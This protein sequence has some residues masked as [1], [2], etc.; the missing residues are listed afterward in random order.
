MATVM[1]TDVV[2]VGAGL[3]GLI[4]ARDLVRAGMSVTVLEAR[5]RVGGRT[6]STELGGQMIDLGGQWIGDKHHKL[7]ALTTE[8]GIATFP[9]YTKGKKILDRGEKLVTFSGF[10][11]RIPLLALAELGLSLSKLERLAKRIPLE[12]PLAERAFDDISLADWLDRN[13]KRRPARELVEL[14]AQMIFAAEPREL[15]FLYF[16]LYVN[17]GQGLRRLAEIKRGAQERRFATG[18]QSVCLELAKALGDRV[19]LDHPVRAVQQDS[20]GVT[21]HTAKGSFRGTR[22]I[23]A[24]PPALLAKLEITPAVSAE[25]ALL[26]TQMPAGSVIKCIAAYERPFWRERGYSGEAFSPNGLVRAVFDDCSADGSH[27]ALVAFVVGDAARELGKL[28]E[29]E[30]RQM[31]LAEL[32]RLHGDAA[33]KPTAYVDKNWLAEEWST[34]CYVGVFAKG[35]LSKVAA[36]LRAP[37]GNI[38]FAGTET[39]IHHLGYLEG[40]LESGE[41]AAAEVIEKRSSMRA[42]G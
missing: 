2:V 17:S 22:A 5:D 31:V 41:R 26:H 6:L 12:N 39:A 24:M 3:A 7:Q 28:P 23:L 19:R 25:R 18:A 36:A 13:V 34:G 38:H 11:P 8:L 37:E 30:R 15:S 29:Q 40:A 42:T 21:V 20:A 4:A 33:H 1:N 9:Q 32:G 35:T 10:L 16:L 27:A 14:A